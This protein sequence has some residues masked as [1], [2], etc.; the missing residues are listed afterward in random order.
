MIQQM[1]VGMTGIVV[2]R[3]GGQRKTDMEAQRSIGW[4]SSVAE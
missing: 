4:V 3:F 2:R 1:A